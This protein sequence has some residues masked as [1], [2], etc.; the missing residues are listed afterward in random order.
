MAFPKN[1]LSAE[2][3][4]SVKPPKLITLRES[5]VFQHNH[6]LW[7]CPACQNRKANQTQGKLKCHQNLDHLRL[8]INL[9]SKC[10]E[11]SFHTK[12]KFW[13]AF[14]GFQIID[15]SVFSLIFMLPRK[16]SSTPSRKCFL[17]IKQLKHII[18]ATNLLQPCLFPWLPCHNCGPNIMQGAEI[19]EMEVSQ[20]RSSTVKL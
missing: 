1:P 12:N 5:S 2:T 4:V 20:T 15:A 16:G 6:S 13:A 18:S 14:F 7:S 17:Q 8:P 10:F 19:L 9:A 11:A 3:P